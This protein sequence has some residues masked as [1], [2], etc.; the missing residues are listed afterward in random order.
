M[1]NISKKVSIA[2]SL[3]ML[4]GMASGCSSSSPSSSSTAPSSSTASSG[5]GASSQ[6]AGQIDTST[7]V[8]LE[9]YVAENNHPADDVVLPAIDKYFQEQINAT[10]NI[11]FIPASEYKDKM[12]PILMSGQTVDIIN[13]N[14]T[15]TS[16][17]SYVD[18]VNQGTF[19]AMDEL[20]PK[21]APKTYEMIPEGF[22]DAM[23]INGN[24]YGIP[25][26]KDSVTIKSLVINKTMAEALGMDTYE[27][28]TVKNM[29][30]VV[31]M[32]YE[33]LEK[34]NATFPEDAN[35]SPYIP[36]T[37][38]CWNIDEW[39]PY[40]S[41]NNI[42]VTNIPGV[43]AYAGKGSGEIVFNKYETDEYRA[44]CQNQAKM[45]NDGVLPADVWNFDTERVYSQQGKYILEDTH[46][47]L[48]EIDPHA[49]SDQWEGVLVPF[50]KTFGSTAYIHNAVECISSS[51]KNPE[52]AMMALEL[53]NTDNFVATALR[54]GLEGQHWNMSDVQGVVSFEG[55]TNADPANRAYYS[56]YGAQFGSLKACYM[57]QGT[58]PDFVD[59][60]LAEN[61]KAILDT[62]MGFVFDPTPVANEVAA[63]SS[64]EGEFTNNLKFGFLV[65][66]KGTDPAVVEETVNK[67]V[68]EFIAKLKENGVDKII[69]EAQ[70]QLD[71]WRAEHK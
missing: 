5:S 68:D 48:I 8:T 61:E 26:Y 35:S 29:Q 7:P 57:P 4:C 34:R 39:A 66:Q 37:R 41:L 1:S 45:V 13:A 6:D 25:S 20:L 28:K 58:S 63:C 65:D 12:T 52:R 21:Y 46:E 18:Y 22:W 14:G 51:S 43:E 53:I 49:F 19:F 56:W 71:A 47:G 3:A 36:I 42:A 44:Y 59:R 50:E 40:E 27:G 64:V 70:K 38:C 33:A 9:W 23:K 2:L 55:T 67:T 24:I 69:E 32:L 54:F 10:M 15:S 30:E 62:N 11:H 17:I 60:L 16:A 31:P